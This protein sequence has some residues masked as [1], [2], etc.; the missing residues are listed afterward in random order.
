[1]KPQLVVIHG[2]M[3]YETHD[4]YLRALREDPVD[5]GYFQQVRKW[6]DR[7][8]ED[9]GGTF[10]ILRPK[11]PSPGNARYS[12]WCIWFERMIPFLRDG[13]ILIGHSLGGIFLARY[14]SEHTLPVKIK[15]TLLLAAPFDDA[16]HEALGDFCITGSL[17]KFESQ[18]GEVHVWNS[19]DDGVVA[20]A[21][22]D[23]YAKALPTAHIRTF[24]DRGHFS[25][26]TFPEIVE[27]L[28][29]L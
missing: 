23:K 14:L 18:G 22:Q 17:A 20:I 19:S 1:M 13:V 24:T 3:V 5:I 29:G 21:E 9:L 8:E 25:L 2:G 6:K 26:E 27:F 16:T 15:A 11:M 4:A 28:K 7:I 12:E 10:D